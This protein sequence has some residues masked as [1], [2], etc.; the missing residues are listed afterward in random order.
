MFTQVTYASGLNAARLL[1]TALGDSSH[2][3][4]WRD[5]GRRVLD[6][7]HRPASAQPCPGLWNDAESRWNRG[8]YPDCKPDARL[9]ASTNLG[10][11]FG[12]L[13]ANDQRADQ[14]RRHAGL[15]L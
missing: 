14:A 5:A 8:V 4:A 10:W 1:A 3:Q 15:C 11:V 13:D 9:D 7:I 12:L 6:A 2:A